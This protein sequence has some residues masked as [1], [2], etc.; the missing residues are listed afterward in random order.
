MNSKRTRTSTKKDEYDYSTS[1]KNYGYKKN[2][3]KKTSKKEKK[4]LE[5]EEDI[6]LQKEFDKQKEKEENLQILKEELELQKIEENEQKTILK[7]QKEIEEREEKEENEKKEIQYFNL[8]QNSKNYKDDHFCH[9]GYDRIINKN[10]FMLNGET[11]IEYCD[12]KSN[13]NQQ[14]EDF[15]CE[16]N[17]LGSYKK[18]PITNSDDTISKLLSNFEK[19]K[20]S[21]TSTEEMIQSILNKDMDME[22]E[23]ELF[24]PAL[25]FSDNEEDVQFISHI[26][27]KDLLNGKNNVKEKEISSTSVTLINELEQQLPEIFSPSTVTQLKAAQNSFQ[28]KP[29]KSFEEKYSINTFPEGSKTAYLKRQNDFVEFLKK[30][31]LPEVELS[32]LNY[33][34]FLKK[35]FNYAPA[36]CWSVF[37]MLNLRSKVMFNVKLTEYHR[38]V[39]FLKQNSK[40][41]NQKQSRLIKFYLKLFYFIKKKLF[42]F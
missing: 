38:L 4:K 5:E 40:K 14:I 13:L 22:E 19:D 8:I 12:S 30:N 15:R 31:A 27:E 32:Y 36:T 1:T 41:K 33:F 6:F 16:R 25:D 18:I 21:E 37:A 9:D 29:K 39:N 2:K 42:K 26:N 24:P 34:Q 7:E 23:K 35:D 20:K 11:A 3:K 17:N 10:C 28:I